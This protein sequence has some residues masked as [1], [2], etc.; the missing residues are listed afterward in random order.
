MT[1]RQQVRSLLTIGLA[2][3]VLTLHAHEDYR[4]VGVITKVTA[5][6]IDVKNKEG[7]SFSIKLNKKTVVSRDKT[8]V[9]ATELKKG[10]TVVVDARGDSEVDLLAEDV[11]IVPGK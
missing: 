6:S 11:R 10:A 4:V 7:K 2:S 5:A 8:V 9:P 1:R 3:S